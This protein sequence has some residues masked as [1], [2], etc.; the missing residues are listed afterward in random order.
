MMG[1]IRAP[2]TPAQVVALNSYQTE[3]AAHPFT[4]LNRGNANHAQP[5]SPDDILVATVRGWICP[6][7]DYTQA[8]AHDFMVTSG[9]IALPPVLMC[10]TSCHCDGR[11]AASECG[12]DPE[13][14]QNTCRRCVT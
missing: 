1:Q 3:G 12:Y 11:K 14:P 5:N 13:F 2:W 7:C 6:F 4:C 10:L 9:P 8:W